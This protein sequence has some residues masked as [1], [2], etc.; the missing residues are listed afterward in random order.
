MPVPEVNNIFMLARIGLFAGL[1]G[2]LLE[3]LLRHTAC[4][5]VGKGERVYWQGDAPGAFYHVLAGRVRCALGSPVGEEK[6]FDVISPGQSFG[7]A[8]L[9]GSGAYTSFAEAVA[10]TT[11]V[12]VDKAG[13][14]EAVADS[15][16]LSLRVLA[17]VADRH[18]TFQRDV[19]ACHFQSAGDRVTD[20]LLGEAAPLRAAAGDTV[21][22]LPMSKNLIAARLGITAETLSRC[23]RELSDAGLI[24]VHGATIVLR[25]ALLEQHGQ[26]PPAA[27]V[28][29]RPRRWHDTPAP[30]LAPRPRPDRGAPARACM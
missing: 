28:Q 4:R 7:L 27:P 10:T 24:E 18:A 14:L 30:V 8:E 3:A 23:L 15:A 6:V 17:A 29:P 19:A 26:C 1:D 13:L 12:Q 11:L 9:F 25:R 5:V 2:A 21:F 20:Y 16:E 22:D